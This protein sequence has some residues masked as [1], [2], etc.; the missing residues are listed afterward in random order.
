VAGVVG[1]ALKA[2]PTSRTPATLDVI[3]DGGMHARIEANI[4]AQV[5]AVGDVVG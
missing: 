3:E 1:L 4:A 5:E 2:S